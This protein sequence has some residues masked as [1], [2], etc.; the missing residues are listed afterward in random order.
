MIKAVLVINNHGKPRLLKFYTYYT[1][2]E[3]ENIVAE[4]F[5]ILSKREGNVCSFLEGGSLIDNT[6]YKLVYRKYCTLYVVFCVDSSESELGIHDIIHVFVQALDQQFEHV[7]ELDFIFHVEKVHHI[8]NELVMGGMVLETNM[9]EIVLRMNEQNDLEKREGSMSN[10]VTAVKNLN[11]PQH[12]K[13][14]KLPDLPSFSSFK[15]PF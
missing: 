14:L 13:D 9:S 11:I 6:D 4:T 5:Q 12:F 8:L 1:E 3:Q 10:A 15:N 7:C 2:E